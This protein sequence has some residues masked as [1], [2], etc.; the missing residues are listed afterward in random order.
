[1]TIGRIV[2]VTTD[3]GTVDGYAGAMTG[4]MLGIAEDL[5]VVA[6]T[7]AL[8]PQDI[9]GAQL[10]LEQAVTCFPA[11]TVHLVVVDPGVGGPRRALAA[12]CGD[13]FFV[14]PDNGVLSAFLMAPH[15]QVVAIENPRYRRDPV[16]PTFHGRD[17]FA[18]AAA[19]LA[20]GIP[21]DELGP[22]V[23][24]PVLT[25]L[26]VA[27]PLSDGG[28]QGE[29]LTTDRFGNLIT[30]VVPSAGSWRVVI[31][32]GRQLPLVRSYIDAPPGGHPVALVGSSGRL[33]IAVAGG[34]AAVWWARELQAARRGGVVKLLAV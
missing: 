29:V 34:S 14:A 1:M 27:T 17:V 31:A 28:L 24:D 21:L 16:A 10:A 5:R 33:E 8:G 15:R 2:T 25:P 23:T 6:I 12:R 9:T 32:D 18:P 13:Q 30:N 26:P 19:Y 11:L 22:I 7:H 3:F 20:S 4:V